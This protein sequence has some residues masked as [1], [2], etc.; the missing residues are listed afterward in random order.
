MRIDDGVTKAER[1]PRVD[2]TYRWDSPKSFWQ[3]SADTGWLFEV[4]AQAI[5][6]LKT[7]Y[8]GD[9]VL[10]QKHVEALMA[11]LDKCRNGD[12]EVPGLETAIAAAGRLGLL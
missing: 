4:Q 12:G 9:L 11:L 8:A 5:N 10:V 1:Q 3:G 7:D 6:I 2:L